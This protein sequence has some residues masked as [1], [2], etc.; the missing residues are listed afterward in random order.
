M[1]EI[2][3]EMKVAQMVALLDCYLVELMDEYMVVKRV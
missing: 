3:V 2:K 1:A